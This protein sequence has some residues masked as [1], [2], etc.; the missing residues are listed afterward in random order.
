P[1]PHPAKSPDEWWKGM[2]EAKKLTDLRD[3]LFAWWVEKSGMFLP[4]DVFPPKDDPCPVCNGKGYTESI[5]TTAD[6]AAPFYDRC[7]N[8]HM[9]T[10]WRVV[11][12]S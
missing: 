4:D 5:V 6:G 3:F 9:A 11:K 2:R 7:S 10:F 1:K 12:F 8:C